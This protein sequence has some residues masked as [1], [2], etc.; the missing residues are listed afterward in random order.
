VF[1]QHQDNIHQAN[2][3]K[4]D[5]LFFPSAVCIITITITIIMCNP[6]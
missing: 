2:S 1:E 4:K 6:S 3:N 5:R